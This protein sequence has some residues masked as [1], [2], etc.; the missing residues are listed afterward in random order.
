VAMNRLRSVH[1]PVIHGKAARVIG[2]ATNDKTGG[3]ISVPT[4]KRSGLGMPIFPEISIT[5]VA[6]D[7]RLN[8]SSVLGPLGKTNPN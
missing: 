7:H 1:R 5:P 4:G 8:N 3:V 2:S 6:S